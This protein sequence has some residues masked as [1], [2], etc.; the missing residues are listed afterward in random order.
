MP[1]GLTPDFLFRKLS[2]APRSDPPWCGW[3]WLAC[4]RAGRFGWR[5]IVELDV[6]GEDLSVT[7]WDI[8]TANALGIV[9]RVRTS[10][11]G[12]D[13]KIDG[14]DKA[15]TAMYDDLKHSD[16]VTHSLIDFSQKVTRAHL[17]LITG[18]SGSAVTGTSEAIGHYD[19]GHYDMAATAQRNA[20][21]AV[22]PATMPGRET[23]SALRPPHTGQG[24]GGL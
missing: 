14:L 24:R 13:G 16:L 8:E 22:H 6:Y 7:E 5:L 1:V 9:G 15:M 12:Y 19:R 11:G 23:G 21:E 3:S 20:K 18:H 2:T 17:N 4:S 10:V